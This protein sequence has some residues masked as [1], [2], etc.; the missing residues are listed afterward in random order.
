MALEPVQCHP[1]AD[2]HEQSGARCQLAR[3]EATVNN[4]KLRKLS[5]HYLRLET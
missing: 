1:N 5:L 4:Q 2:G 3:T